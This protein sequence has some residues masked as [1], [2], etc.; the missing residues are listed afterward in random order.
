MLNWHPQTQMP[1]K[2]TGQQD[3]LP[4]V[5]LYRRNILDFGSEFDDYSKFKFANLSQEGIRPRGVKKTAKT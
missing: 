1:L 3:F 4:P 5:F 2:R